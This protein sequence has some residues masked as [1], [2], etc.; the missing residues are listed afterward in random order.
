MLHNFHVHNLNSHS[1]INMVHGF[2]NE[3]ILKHTWFCFSCFVFAC[4]WTLHPLEQGATRT[5]LGPSRKH[6]S[7]H[8]KASSRKHAPNVRQTY[9]NRFLNFWNKFTWN[10]NDHKSK[11]S[12]PRDYSK[13]LHQE[14]K[15]RKECSP[16]LTVSR[17]AEF[18]NMSCS[19]C[20]NS[21]RNT[22]RADQQ[23]NTRNF[24]TIL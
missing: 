11:S 17:S 6:G 23:H 2:L 22:H 5:L 14:L 18:L 8:V 1:H 19:P 20:D 16:A 9:T 3:T 24:W 4:A 13:T 10:H 21:Y 7:Y 12:M 15:V